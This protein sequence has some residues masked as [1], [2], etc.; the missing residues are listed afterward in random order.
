MAL[1]HLVQVNIARMRAPIDDPVMADFVARLDEVNALADAAP[2][3]VWRLQTDEGDATALRPYDDPMIIVNMSVWE[4]IEAL[5]EFVYRRQHAQ[6]MRDRRR[7][8]QPMDAAYLAMW[9]LPAGIL[10][11]VEDAVVRLDHLRLHGD[12]AV[13]FGVRNPHPPPD[14]PTVPQ[15]LLDQPRAPIDYHERAFASVSNTSNG[16][17]GRET[18]FRYRQRGRFVCAT[19]GGG[20]VSLGTLVAVA[21]DEGRLDMR[22]Q[23]ANSAGEVRTGRCTSTP[24]RLPHG[25]LRMHESW[26]WTNGDLSSG[27][28][29][30]EEI[31]L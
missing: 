3:F 31:A 23:H 1:H 29:V 28:A 26:Q 19:Y 24:E 25:G 20:G 6:V 8:F 17:V 18:R 12:S 7:W 21:D 22:Y 9:W 30:L 14:E 10:P 2:G 15:P 13:V 16:E 11:S 4:S 5:R 27:R